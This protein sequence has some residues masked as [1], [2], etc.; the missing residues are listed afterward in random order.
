VN[1]WS[2]AAL[3]LIGGLAGGYAFAHSSGI[4]E[5]RAQV[6]GT[7]NDLM[8]RN[9]SLQGQI[10]SLTQANQEYEA[11]LQRS[12]FL[13]GGILFQ[14]RQWIIPADVEPIYVGH[15]AQADYTHFDPKTQTETVH[16]K[17]K[18]Q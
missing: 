9:V 1:K 5:G 7:V 3:A 12:T 13:Y 17:P 18:Q 6:Q 4:E 14:S 2:L 11:K 8:S 15:E 16:L 10:Q